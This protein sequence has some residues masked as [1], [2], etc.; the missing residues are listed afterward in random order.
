MRLIFNFFLAVI[1][2]ILVRNADTENETEQEAALPVCRTKLITEFSSK[3]II[4]FNTLK[5][6]SRA[7]F[8]VKLNQ[9]GSPTYNLTSNLT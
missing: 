5:F 1:S 8:H 4:L 3:N 7:K 6:N 2:L 9:P